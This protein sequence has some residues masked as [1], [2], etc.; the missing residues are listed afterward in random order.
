MLSRREIKK[1][2][3]N[4]NNLEIGE[5]EDILSELIEN[6]K[7]QIVNGEYIDFLGRLYR[8]KEALFK[9]IFV[10]TKESKKYIVSMHGHMVSKKNILYTLKKKY[11][12]YNGNLIHG[13]TQYI[14]RY[15]KQT[16]RMDKVLEILN[17]QKLENLIKLRNESPV[18]HGFKGVSRED[19]ESIYGS[20]MEVIQDLIKA[21]E[22]LDL[23]INTT[24]YEDIN[25]IIIELLSKYVIY[26]GD[27]KLE[28]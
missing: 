4:L 19:I 12:I 5:P 1:L 22:M 28:R 14:K 6:I 11:N 7:I 26:R 2:I 16:K 24:K 25:D 20:P 27:E 23:G 9:Y 15:I 10:S 3:T 17:S 21:C 13:V 18:G 8:L